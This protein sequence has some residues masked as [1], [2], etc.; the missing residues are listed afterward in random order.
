M[1][2]AIFMCVVFAVQATA[3][4]Y[5]VE[6][7]LHLPG[8]RVSL[9]NAGPYLWVWRLFVCVGCVWVCVCV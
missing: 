2:I 4:A 9:G 1:R 3:K 8:V 6:G 5:D 7:V